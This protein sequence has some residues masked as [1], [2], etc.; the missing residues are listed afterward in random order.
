[1]YSYIFYG[2]SEYKID[3]LDYQNW[4]RYFFLEKE[5]TLVSLLNSF[6]LAGR[7]TRIELTL[8]WTK[9]KL[10]QGDFIYLQISVISRKKRNGKSNL[11]IH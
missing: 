2:V 11:H 1:M 10:S 3:I 8:D 6:R 5:M 4:S 9:K 7:H